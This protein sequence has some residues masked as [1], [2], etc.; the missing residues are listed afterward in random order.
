MICSGISHGFFCNTNLPLP[1]TEYACL[2]GGLPKY[3]LKPKRIFQRIIQMYSD[4]AIITSTQAF[5]ENIPVTEKAQLFQRAD[6]PSLQQRSCAGFAP[7]FLRHILHTAKSVKSIFNYLNY[8]PLIL[9]CQ[10]RICQK[11]S[12]VQNIKSEPAW[13]AWGL[14]Y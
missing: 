3:L 4:L 2:Y 1:K 8:T 11:G 10:Y 6:A 7:G 14:R 12:S 5:P 9:T 13:P